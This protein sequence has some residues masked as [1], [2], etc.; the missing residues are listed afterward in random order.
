MENMSSCRQQLEALRSQVKEQTD[1]LSALETAFLQEAEYLRRYDQAR[2]LRA[3]HDR[4]TQGVRHVRRME[5]SASYSFNW[6]M[7][8]TG[9]AKLAL[10]SLIAAKRHSKEHPLT[11]GLEHAK[12]DFS[13]TAPF[14]TVVVA[15]GPKGIPDDVKVISLSHCARERS[16]PESEI[17]AAIEDRGY[18]LIEPKS[19]LRTL[20]EL[21]EQVL[22]GSVTFPVFD[23]GL[24]PH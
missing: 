7:T 10:W 6:A 2:L 13:R 1:A 19:F 24:A 3:L 15:V 20:E 8:I 4:V 21:K 9:S 17:V 12:S 5:E 22:K 11:I 14:G 16:R 23:P 18:Q